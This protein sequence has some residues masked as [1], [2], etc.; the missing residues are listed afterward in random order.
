MEEEGLMDILE[1]IKDIRSDSSVP[2]NV[3]EVMNE[4]KKCFENSKSEL[5]LKVDEA[6][7][8]LEEVSID[9]AIPSHTRTQI[10]NITSVL[11][12]LNKND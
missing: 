11:E 10:W 1:I 6:M 4:I 9:P 3:K 5:K 12:S 2:R 7:P 8:K